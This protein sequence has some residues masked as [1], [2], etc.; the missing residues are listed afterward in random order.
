[1][2]WLWLAH[3]ARLPK[4]YDGDVVGLDP[5]LRHAGRDLFAVDRTPGLVAGLVGLD[6]VGSYTGTLTALTEAARAQLACM[7]TYGRVHSALTCYVVGR[8]PLPEPARPRFQTYRR[9]HAPCLTDECAA[10]LTAALGEG[11]R[12]SLRDQSSQAALPPHTEVHRLPSV[13]ISR[14]LTGEW[15]ELV[16]SPAA[17]PRL[18]IFFQHP[19]A[20]VRMSTAKLHN[21][22]EAFNF[23]KLHVIADMMR[24]LPDVNDDVHDAVLWLDTVSSVLHDSGRIK[25]AVDKLITCRLLARLLKATSTLREVPCLMACVLYY[26]LDRHVRPARC[27]RDR[28]SLV[29]PLDRPSAARLPVVCL[30]ARLPVRRNSGYSAGAPRG[31][32]EGACR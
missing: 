7:S 8:F 23:S 9:S 11:A 1:M 32:A 14:I 6:V 17:S 5:R 21:F 18:S 22:G 20:E 30:P 13:H 3:R 31:L 28:S 27:P 16:L 24:S 4:R 12:D 25:F 15:A 10:E 29:C 19:P 2:F 26:P